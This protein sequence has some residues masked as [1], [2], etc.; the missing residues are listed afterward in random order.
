LA[1]YTASAQIST[2]MTLKF[3]MRF[4]IEIPIVPIP[5]PRSSTTSQSRTACMICA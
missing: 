5:Q 3:G 1:S 2:P 4:L